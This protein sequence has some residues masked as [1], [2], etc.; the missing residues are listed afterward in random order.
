MTLCGG[1]YDKHKKNIQLQEKVNDSIKFSGFLHKLVMK[2][3]LIFTKVTKIDYQKVD[4]TQ[5]V[6]IFHVFIEHT[7]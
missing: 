4:K 2:F 5:T 3:D 6:I 1:R 7:H